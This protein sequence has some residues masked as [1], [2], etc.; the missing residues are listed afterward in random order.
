MTFRRAAL[1]LAALLAGFVCVAA[2]GLAHAKEPLPIYYASVLPAK[3]RQ[4]AVRDSIGGSFEVS[5]FA[6]FKD[7][8]D[9]IESKAPNVLIA[10]SFFGKFHPEYE[11]V[12]RFKA[13]AGNSFKYQILSLSAQWNQK[14]LAGGKLGMVEEESRDRLKDLV[15]EL[16]GA[17]VKLVKS[18]SK[19][20][21]L[22]PLLIF[23][24]ADFILIGPQERERLSEKFTA[25]VHLVG[26][27]RA[28]GLP[29]VFVKKGFS[30]GPLLEALKGI[31][32]GACNALGFAAVEPYAKE[33][34]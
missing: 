10:P 1:P 32:P 19:P 24:S 2:P 17:K 25:K 14:N 7:F 31:S 30:N 6:K 21:D 28:V 33:E 12:L 27:S 13:S 3:E 23:K 11:P 22:F 4:E 8:N 15:G 29:V 34:P 26:E 9:E 20:E 18:V 16:L 5:V